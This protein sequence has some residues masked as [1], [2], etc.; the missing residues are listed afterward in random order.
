MERSYTIECQTEQ[1]SGV[2][3]GN[4]QSIAEM[5]TTFMR[6]IAI[7]DKA[8]ADMECI[9]ELFKDVIFVDG[10]E[11]IKTLT[12][13][14][15]LLQQLCDVGVD[16][17]SVLVAVGGG[18]V[19]DLVGF[20]A[21]TYMRGVR[22]VLIPTT[23]LGQVDAA[24]GG[25][26]AVN[27]GGFKNMVGAFALPSQ[28]VCDPS[29]LTSLPEREW[30]AGMAE[31]IKTAIIGDEE[32]FR[33]LE[34]TTLDDIRQSAALTEEIVARCVAVKCDI[35]QRDL[36]E[37]GERRLLNLGHTL[38]HAIES[39]S[40][41]FSHGEAV[42][43]GIAYA[44]RKAVKMG[45]LAPE[46]AVRIERL[47]QRYD[48]PTELPLAEEALLEVVAHDKKTVNGTPHWVLPTE[49][50]KCIVKKEEF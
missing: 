12:S 8:V 44:S 3:I 41:E 7:V 42:A 39:L 6:T 5:Y 20:V 11:S 19:T 43:V 49:I 40:E 13:A 48:L 30:R 1:K 33:T 10:G 15:E 28:V 45:V 37:S 38:A 2:K 35:V 32:L 31:V 18:T 21:A 46:L 23:L 47:L 36:R 22:C 25:K 4:W 29:W 16:R 14:G 17:Q 50:G 26:C 27:M 9:H 34:Q 24:I